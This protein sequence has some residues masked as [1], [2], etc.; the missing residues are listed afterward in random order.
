MI[1]GR[2]RDHPHP[3]HRRGLISWGG[4]RRWTTS[5]PHPTASPRRVPQEGI[6]HAPHKPPAPSGGRRRGLAFLLAATL[7]FGAAVAVSALAELGRLR[8]TA[9]ELDAVAPHLAWVTTAV[10]LPIATVALRGWLL[11][12]I[13][14]ALLLV[15]TV[16][17]GV[18]VVLPEFGVRLLP[19][20]ELVARTGDGRIKLVA[21]QVR[22]RSR[23]PYIALCEEAPLIPGVRW[24][25]L[26]ARVGPTDGVA[27]ADQGRGRYRC[28]FT[29]Y[30][31]RTPHP[32]MVHLRRW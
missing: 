10:C 27:I 22:H 17:C 29:S 8:F 24:T 2:H 31:G 30:L 25:R 32:R 23:Q 11:G 28:S 18:F 9:P 16:A 5:S 14:V 26:L 15:T 13:T 1:D 19:S 3:H 12:L 7:A 6:I 4:S 21:L 20:A